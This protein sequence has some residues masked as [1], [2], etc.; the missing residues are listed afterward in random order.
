MLTACTQ[1]FVWGT[2]MQCYLK[3]A[4]GPLVD[5][6]NEGALGMAVGADNVYAGTLQAGTWTKK[7][8]EQAAG[9]RCVAQLCRTQWGNGATTLMRHLAQESRVGAVG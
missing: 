5:A 2:N 4:S 7:C 1:G 9:S 3:R 8:R 6:G